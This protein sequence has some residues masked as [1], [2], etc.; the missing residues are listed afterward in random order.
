MTGIVTLEIGVLADSCLRMIVR[1]DLQNRLTVDR[2]LYR[3]LL[4][5]CLVVGIWIERYL[6]HWN[7]YGQLA[8]GVLAAYLLVASIQDAQSREVYDFL[9]MM[10]L[11][12][13]LIFV[14]AEPS[15]DKLISLAVFAAVQ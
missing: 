14:V 15:L 9:H 1:E 5:Y 12:T 8:C 10:T 2:K 11:P 7:W 6:V 4:S 3:K 13:G